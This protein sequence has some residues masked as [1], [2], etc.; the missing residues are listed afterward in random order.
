MVVKSK[1]AQQAHIKQ[2]TYLQ[3]EKKQKAFST[4]KNIFTRLVY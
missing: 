4:Q 1:I 2:S 3:S